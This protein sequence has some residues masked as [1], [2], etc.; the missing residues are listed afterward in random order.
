MARRLDDTAFQGFGGVVHA[1]TIPLLDD[2]HEFISRVLD[3]LIIDNPR[4][5]AVESGIIQPCP[6][7]EELI[8][9]VTIIPAEAILTRVVRQVWLDSTLQCVADRSNNEE[10]K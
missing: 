4:G 5:D 7:G 8:K 9:A 10:S 6:F 2:R 1:N 3:G